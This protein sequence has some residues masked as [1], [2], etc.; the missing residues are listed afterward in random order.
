MLQ[1]NHLLACLPDAE[2][3]RIHHHLELVELAL[4]ASVYEAGDVLNTLYF[5]IDSIIS[6]LYVMTDG[7]SAE[8]AIVGN[9]GVYGL[10]Q[11][12]GD[13]STNSRAVVQSGGKAFRVEARFLK[14]E[15]ESGGPLRHL[16]LRYTQ[17][18]MTQMMQTGACNR[19]HPVDQQLCRW[20]LMSL[21]RM[22]T[23]S[24]VMTEGLIAN[25]LGVRRIG[26]TD[27]TG[28]LATAGLIRYNAGHIHIL[29]RPGLEQYACECYGVVKLEY[30]RLLPDV[31]AS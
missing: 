10:S 7:D 15:F 9:D 12:M 30:D 22:S 13:G 23:D 6:V 31:I 19:H 16:L 11:F 18:L 20:L 4:G 27:A 17:A 28:K 14:N 5:P 25:M 2:H 24:L 21:D 1:K 8:I 26:V 29:D 3:S